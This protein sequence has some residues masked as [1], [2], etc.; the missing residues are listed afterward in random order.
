MLARREFGRCRRRAVNAPGTRASRGVHA[1][2]LMPD[3]L[4]LLL[5]P[6]EPD[7]PWRLMQALARCYGEY[8]DRRYARR[9]M[10]CNL[11]LRANALHSD[12]DLLACSRHIEFDPVRAGMGVRAR[13]PPLVELPRQWPGRPRR[14]AHPAR[15]VP[16][17]RPDQGRTAAGVPRV[18]RAAPRRDLRSEGG[19]PTRSAAR[20]RKSGIL[21][22]IG[23]SN[24]RPP[25]TSTTIPLPPLSLAQGTI[26]ACAGIP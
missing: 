17:S 15:D 4:H 18:V 16:R 19:S 6:A 14:G 21:A 5:T 7:G 3:H 26:P 9:G 20:P 10:S 22:A 24:P 8:L 23:M 25:L 12:R 1:Y 11:V 13:R 2:V